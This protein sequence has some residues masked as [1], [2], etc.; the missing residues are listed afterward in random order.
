LKYLDDYKFIIYTAILASIGTGAAMA[1]ADPLPW[2][3]NQVPNATASDVPAFVPNVVLN[4]VPHFAPVAGSNVIVSIPT[5]SSADPDAPIVVSHAEP[6]TS[7]GFVNNVVS[8]LASA[9]LTDPFSIEKRAASMVSPGLKPDNCSVP[10]IA[11]H[12]LRFG[13]VVIGV[14]CNNPDTK[15]A[16]LGLVA[17]SASFA[18][19]YSAYLPTVSASMSH[20]RTSSFGNNSKST[21]VSSSYGVTTGLTLYDFGQREFRL[22]IA[23]LGL[24]AAGHSYNSTLQGTIASALQGYYQLLTS[25]N[26]VE[27]ARQSENFAKES[28]DAAALR[29]Q[30]GLVPLSDELQAKSAYSQSQLGSEQAQNQLFLDQAALAQQMGMPADTPIQVAELDNGILVRDPF[31]GKVQQL[32]EEA[33]LKRDDLQATKLQ[34]KGAKDSL[35][36]LKRSDLATLSVSANMGLNNE[37]T[38]VLFGRNATRSQALGLSVSIPIFTGYSTTYNELA[39]HKSLEAQEEQLTK[40]ELG[41]EQDVWNSWHNYQ[42]AKK[43]WETSQDLFASASLLKDVSLGRYKEG[44]GT[45]L[46]VLNAESQYSAALQSQLQTRFGLLTSRVNLVRSVGALNLDTMRPETTV[47]TTA[48]NEVPIHE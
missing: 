5:A 20:G 11:D 39:A 35:Q 8:H 29:H 36:A 28:Y 19:N 43:S 26:A 40:T 22:E 45:I 47:Q 10:Q 34:L 33:K 12:K 46:D 24:V 38:S 9:L 18:T 6:E 23:E 4:D 13:D 30:I 7:T 31:N 1:H 48:D 44:L 25:Q 32:I 15:A 14:L 17:Q 27:V 2:V 16:Y 37:N 41:V 21:A 42:T 3:S